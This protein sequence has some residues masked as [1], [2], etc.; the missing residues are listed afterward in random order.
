MTRTRVIPC[1]LL[2]GHGLVKTRRFKDP[3]YIGD[4]VNAVRI[5]SEK[6]A[7]ELIILDIDATREGREPNYELIAEIAGE[8]FMPVAYGGGIKT[9]DQARRI[10]RSG[11][12]KIV[13][14]SA[15]LKSQS[16][17]CEI[18]NTFGSQAVVGAIDAKKTLFS[19]YH[20]FEAS[21]S[22]DTGLRVEEHAASLERAGVGEIFLNSIDGDG[23]MQGFDLSLIQ[24]VVKNVCIP[25][26]ACGGAGNGEHLNEA[27]AKGGASAV[28]AGSMFVYYGKH[29]AVLI[30]YSSSI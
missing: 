16:V 23:Q 15:A 13:I 8:C 2:R 17:I 12:E 29:K 18:V 27:I 4:P 14:N 21:G 10:I 7:D 25:I 5:F 30:N 19:G 20:V 9:L 22:K 6:E 26:I 28:A 1:L 11:V 3:T 24:A